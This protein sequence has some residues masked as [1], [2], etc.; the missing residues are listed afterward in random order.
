MLTDEVAARAG[1]GKGSIYRQFGSKEQLYAEAVI[2]GFVQL[3]RRIES[4]LDDT[5]SEHERIKTIAAQML[6]YFWDRGQFFVLMRDPT[7]LPRAQ[8]TRFLSERAKVSS[9][10]GKLL[11]EHAR[12]GRIRNDL[13]FDLMTE[14]LLGMIRGIRRFKSDRTTLDDAITTV[15]AL[16]LEGALRGGRSRDAG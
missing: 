11:R 5:H 3:R 12:S 7:R 2:D 15:V 9:L 4:A 10:I 1:V 8:H 14:A 13:D 16:F 6:S